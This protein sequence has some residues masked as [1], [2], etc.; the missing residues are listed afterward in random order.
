MERLSTNPTLPAV[1]FLGPG[2]M[3]SGM[4]L[5]LLEA[6]YHVGVWARDPL[7]LSPLV[8]AGAAAPASVQDVVRSS[9]IVLGC[10]LDSAVIRAVYLGPGGI[11]ESARPG[12]LF[13]EHA[14][15]DPG[16]A[17]EI[18]HA[19]AENGAAFADAPV[20][21]GPRGA[22][23]GTL[24]TMIG[25]DGPVFESLAPILHSYCSRLVHVGGVGSGLKV[26]LI[27]Q[28]LVSAH[29]VVAAEA[30]AL[31]RSN[32]ID[33]EVA[34]SALMGGWAASAMLD[35]QLPAACAGDF[36]DG[37]ASI[38]GLIE[39]QRLVANLMNEA[40]VD[41]TLLGPIRGAF[42]AA[43]DAGHAG[44]SLAA[45]VTNYGAN[46]P[47]AGSALSGPREDEQ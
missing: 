19:L 32:G 14:T 41:S 8:E 21:G 12:Q 9:D 31:V 27:N 29:A 2:A 7:K 30:A 16:L 5:S 39:V 17:V 34:H 4:V 18:S 24:V 13:A 28:L 25:A 22:L 36:D 35:M 44:H 40:G 10:L 47:A 15:F 6:G 33:P 11:A 23:E 26:K 1:G 37:G 20:S 46:G 42:G 43:V 3:G 45:L 38:G